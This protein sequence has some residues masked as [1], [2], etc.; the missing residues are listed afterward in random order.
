MKRTVRL[1]LIACVC[2]ATPA[3]AQTPPAA[4]PAPQPP[5]IVGPAPP[6]ATLLEGFRPANGS[7]LT[8]GY[9]DLGDV[10]NISVD[11][12]EM[13]DSS[14]GA[15]ARGVVVTVGNRRGP[16]EQSYVDEDELPELLKGVD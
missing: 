13:R 12:R 3:G 8:I 4:G 9:D 5:V 6:P 15:R 16:H 1:W 10:A 2:L 11:V 7:V 14:S